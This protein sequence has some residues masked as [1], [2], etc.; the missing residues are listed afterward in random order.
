M[1]ARLPSLSRLISANNVPLGISI[2]HRH[3]HCIRTHE[4]THTHAAD[5]TLSHIL[6]SAPHRGRC[7]D[8]LFLASFQEC[9][10]VSSVSFI[11]HEANI[12]R[13]TSQTLC[14]VNYQSFISLLGQNGAVIS[15]SQ[16][17]SHTR[18]KEHWTLAAGAARGRRRYKV[19]GTDH[20]RRQDKLK[21]RCFLS[22][23]SSV[24]R[25]VCPFIRFV[26]DVNV[27]LLSAHSGVLA[28]SVSFWTPG[29]LVN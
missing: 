13:A 3:H 18:V 22:F 4:R 26:S 1:N 15:V 10:S 17:L 11:I 16:Q 24:I 25:H 29:L 28:W 20:W 9:T 21:G 6:F 2:L 27:L 5:G 7:Q 23:F 14:W 19:S 12:H 8:R